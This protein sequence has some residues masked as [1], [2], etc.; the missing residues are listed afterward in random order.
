MQERAIASFAAFLASS[1]QLTFQI[2]RVVLFLNKA[3]HNRLQILFSAHLVAAGEK[4]ENVN[5]C[6]YLNYVVAV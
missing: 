2:F 6:K 4:R 5:N 1:L 3:H